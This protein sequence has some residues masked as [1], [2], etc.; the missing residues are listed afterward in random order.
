MGQGN[1][2]YLTCL[3]AEARC[4]QTRERWDFSLDYPAATGGETGAGAG[5]GRDGVS[6]RVRVCDGVKKNL[7]PKAEGKAAEEITSDRPSGHQG[8]GHGIR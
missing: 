8:T 5:A 7:F 4:G 1:Y 2:L 3:L 6:M